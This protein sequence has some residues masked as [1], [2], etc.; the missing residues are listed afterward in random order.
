MNETIDVPLDGEPKNTLTVRLRS[1]SDGKPTYQARRIIPV[2]IRQNQRNPY[3]T[4]SLGTDDF[5]RAI[6]MARQ[7]ERKLFVKIDSGEPIKDVPFDEIARSYLAWIS[8]RAEVLD[9]SGEPLA[10]DLAIRREETSI[11]RYLVPFFG[12]IDVRRI[13]KDLVEKYVEWRL[14]YYV[15]GP[16]TYETEIAF[17]RKGKT[18]QRPLVKNARPAPSTINKDAVAFSKVIDH[19]KRSTGIRT[20]DV[21]R[22]QVPRD[23]KQKTRRRARFSDSAWELLIEEARARCG[24]NGKRTN[25]FRFVL[26][27]FLE[28][29]RGTGMRVS[30]AYWLQ[31]KHLRMVP[32]QSEERSTVVPEDSEFGPVFELPL[33]QRHRDND[34]RLLELRFQV[35]RDNPGLKQADHARVT[36][37]TLACSFMLFYYLDF[38]KDWHNEAHGTHF[39]GPSDLPGDLFLFVDP[40]GKRIASM[41]GSFDRLLEAAVSDEFP[42]GLKTIGGQS[43][44]LSC[45]RHTYASKQIEAGGAKNGVGGLADNMGT[46]TEMIR[47]HYGQAL[48][49]LRAE[50]LQLE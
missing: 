15:D 23:R 17:S 16:G 39:N 31:V 47:R 38:L 18:L 27:G 1:R 28:L 34:G 5:N 37:P 46:S 14:D 30:E 21:P 22:I 19:A 10:N 2:S 42:D 26:W 3:V 50:E 43:M 12:K 25:H 6:S 49:E 40:A 24:W 8:K 41:K 29:L 9:R 4:K 7:W 20:A 36:I 48:H 32:V 11:A 45:I 35:A 33:P 44:S 13:T